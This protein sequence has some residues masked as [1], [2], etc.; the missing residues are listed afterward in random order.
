VGIGCKFLDL[1][2]ILG[3]NGSPTIL[4][5]FC[6]FNIGAS[7][8]GFAS[9]NLFIGL[10]FACVL[11]AFYSKFIGERIGDFIFGE[12][13]VVFFSILIVRV[14]AVLFASLKFFMSILLS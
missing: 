6:Y 5:T 2:F 13:I 14:H 11:A 10:K 7:F 8:K 9:F 12:L 4:D 1:L 3:S